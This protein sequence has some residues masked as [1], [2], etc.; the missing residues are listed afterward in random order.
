MA[1]IHATIIP[2]VCIMVIVLHVEPVVHVDP[3]LLLL[4]CWMNWTAES[5]NQ[6][7]LQTSPL[8]NVYA[9][10][11]R[12][13]THTM[14]YDTKVTQHLKVRSKF[15]NDT[16]TITTFLNNNLNNNFNVKSNRQ[17]ILTWHQNKKIECQIHVPWTYFI[18]RLNQTR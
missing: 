9:T 17:M 15:R 8:H 6:F 12:L 1:A 4:D 3:L 7:L 14:N 16:A 10:Y 13:N 18:H 5:K 2:I 11:V